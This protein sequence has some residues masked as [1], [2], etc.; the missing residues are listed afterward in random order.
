MNNQEIF[1]YPKTKTQDGTGR[2]I[3]QKR[4]P[5]TER[6]ETINNLRINMG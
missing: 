6:E 2:T 4:K 5:K 1:A 3:H